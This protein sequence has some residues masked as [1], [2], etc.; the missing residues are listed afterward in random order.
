[1]RAKG[2]TY[3]GARMG[4]PEK[5]R[6]RKMSPP[7]HFLF[8][9]G[10]AGG[11][12]RNLMDAVKRGSIEVELNRRRCTQ[13]GAVTYK[14]QCDA[15]GTP[16]VQERTCPSCKRVLEDEVCPVC[17]RETV[18]YSRQ[19]INIRDMLRRAVDR[20]GIQPPRLVKGVRGLANADKTPEPIEKGILRARH[21]LYVFKDGTIRFDATDAP[22]TH[23][24]PSEI[25]LPLERLWELGYTHD[26]NGDRIIDGEQI[27]EL[28]IHDVIVPESCGDYLVKVAQFLDDL[29]VRVYSQPPYYNVRTRDDL[30]GHLIIGL[31]PH[32]SAGV[33]GRIIGFTKAK[34]C[35]AHPLWHN[36]KRRDCD[37]DEDS[38]MLAL[39]V[40]LNFSR[41]YLPAQIGG[42][43]DAPLLI[44]SAIDP[45]EVD[46][47]QNI[48]VASRYPL[49]FY[50]GASKHAD[51]EVLRQVIDTISC[52]LGTPAQF[53]G[54][55]FTH[56]TGDINGENHKSAYLKLGSMAEKL[57]SQLTLAEK[58]RAVDAKEVAKRVLTT[59]FIRDIVGNL[60]AFT[61]QQFRCKKCNAKYR[62][63]PV[64]GKC[65]RCGGE[66]AVTVHR[67]GI[68][69][70]LN[71][72]D[73]L[74][75]KYGLSTYYHQR[76]EL[77]K[78]EINSLFKV[79]AREK[80]KQATLGRFM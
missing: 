37:G 39:D 24:K 70:Y 22:L 53:E 46:E 42:M 57:E 52:R 61:S 63:V 66:L 72:A 79:K 65:L 78:D 80:E 64:A 27:C 2:V 55:S 49:A 54:Y 62:R 5:A 16:T 68:E 25:G 19:L 15:C 48:D 31:A 29:L 44:I 38:I 47:A 60:Q 45:F 43:M 26:W 41:A 40:L 1:V 34:V 12:R 14:S 76:I 74:T 67:G 77:V 30:I 21:D 51:P 33:L 17:K 56:P 7:V 32:T 69:K 4:R 8:P 28:K 23:F 59:H 6:E 35:Y 71:A 73:E 13:C 9:V 50:D 3:V 75:K 10:L 20:L 58:L 18:G 11:P 36:V